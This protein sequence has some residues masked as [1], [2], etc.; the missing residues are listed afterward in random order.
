MIRTLLLLALLPLTAGRADAV[1]LGF[2]R[3]PGLDDQP[4]AITARYLGRD[5]ALANSSRPA[6]VAA[7]AVT[8]ARLPARTPEPAPVVLSLP[9]AMPHFLVALAGLARLAQRRRREGALAGRRT[10]P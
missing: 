10:A 1:P 6:L 9:G 2:V 8:H 4:P 7:W 3:D 5:M